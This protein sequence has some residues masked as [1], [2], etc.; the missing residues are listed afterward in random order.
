MT[1]FE[2]NIAHFL[3]GFIISILLISTSFI[4]IFVKIKLIIFKE[5]EPSVNLQIK[6]K[7]ISKC[8]YCGTEFKSNPLICYKCS[9]EIP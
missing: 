6:E 7:K 4:G 9:N 1:Y 8:P 2:M 3:L 5:K